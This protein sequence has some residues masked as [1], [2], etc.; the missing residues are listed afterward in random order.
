MNT[1]QVTLDPTK[2]GHDLLTLDTIL[3]M[4]DQ[5]PVYLSDGQRISY[6]MSKTC[7][8]YQL[9]HVGGKAR[10]YDQLMRMLDR[11]PYIYIY[12]QSSYTKDLRYRFVLN[13]NK[14]IT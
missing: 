10:G 6:V 7:P 3:G 9:W 14:N 5:Y 12:M 2:P 4:S 8:T 13:L 11:H 1:I